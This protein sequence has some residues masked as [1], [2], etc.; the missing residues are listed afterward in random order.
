MAIQ[1]LKSAVFSVGAKHWDRRLFDELIPLPEGTTYNAYLIQGSE[2]TALIDTVDPE[3]ENDLLENLE[4]LEVKNID[5][6][7]A[8]HA[9]QDHSG[10]IPGILEKYS[11]AR[12]VTNEKCKKMLIDLLQI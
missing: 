8:N 11:S 10:A 12:V 4:K 9:E 3:K 1:Q 2:K 5:Y 7:I 6:V